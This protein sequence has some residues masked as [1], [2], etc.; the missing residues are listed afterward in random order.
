[1]GAIETLPIKTESINVTEVKKL[2]A[3]TANY[4]YRGEEKVECLIKA[5]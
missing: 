1:M 5:G 2:I 3:S 4:I